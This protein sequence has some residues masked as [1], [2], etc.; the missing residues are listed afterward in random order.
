[1]TPSFKS[2]Y[3]R[4]CQ[5][6]CGL[7]TT[8]V[9]AFATCVESHAPSAREALFFYALAGDRVDYLMRCVKME[10]LRVEYSDVRA[11][12]ASMTPEAALSCRES[13]PSRYAKSL[14]CYLYESRRTES[15]RRLVA[16]YRHRVKSLLAERTPKVTMHTVA[17]T[18][19]ADKSNLYGWLSKDDDTKV[20]LAL[21]RRVYD[22]L[23][24]LQSTEIISQTERNARFRSMVKAMKTGA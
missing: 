20:S 9:K 14:S 21:A 7:E 1:M 10:S 18:I 2:Y 8:S 19:G 6:L 23:A 22:C 13:L 4:E 17:K 11:R 12:L 24:P 5:R 16:A 3:L 15:N